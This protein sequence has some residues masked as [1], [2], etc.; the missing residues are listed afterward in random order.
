M[1]YNVACKKSICNDAQRLITEIWPF[2][3][4][5]SRNKFS[6]DI[7]KQATSFGTP[8]EE[9]I[10]QLIITHSSAI[11]YHNFMTII[12]TNSQNW[13]TG[14][15]II[16]SLANSHSNAVRLDQLFE[17][18]MSYMDNRAITIPAPVYKPD[19]H[20]NIHNFIDKEWTY[21]Y[22]AQG[23][24]E[25]GSI[26]HIPAIFNNQPLLKDHIHDVIINNPNLSLKQT[27]E[28]IIEETNLDKESKYANQQKFINFI[29]SKSKGLASNYMCL[30][31]LR[32]AGWPTETDEEITKSTKL[33]FIKKL[34][35]KTDMCHSHVY[36]M[37]L[38][39]TWRNYATIW[40]VLT[41]LREADSN[42]KGN[43]ETQPETSVHAQTL[44][45]ISNSNISSN[46]NDMEVDSISRR[47]NGNSRQRSNNF[48]RN[49]N[50]RLLL[51]FTYHA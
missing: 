44:R 38:S 45:P 49:N 8:S 15:T 11:S 28:K 36:S 40:Q 50:R 25:T 46:S 9:D 1:S 29:Y 26:K 37:S 32:K 35:I 24:S 13:T 43:D 6:A 14:M 27:I 47:F 12:D 17:L 42:Y 41:F 2:T 31:Q 10:K 16:T 21:W 30:H 7:L 18:T 51:F 39:D 22:T 33:K 3:T 23:L 19:I 20:H 34:N 5:T 48:I 4:T